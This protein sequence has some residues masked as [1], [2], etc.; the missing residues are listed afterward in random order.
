MTGVLEQGPCGSREERRHSQAPPETRKNVKIPANM[1]RSPKVSI[2]R[3][4]MVT[5]TL[6]QSQT[7][8]V[9]PWTLGL[10]PSRETLPPSEALP[11]SGVPSRCHQPMSGTAS[12]NLFPSVAAAQG[13]GGVTR[14]GGC[15]LQERPAAQFQ[16]PEPVPARQR[17]LFGIPTPH[18][19]LPR[20]QANLFLGSRGGWPLSSGTLLPQGFSSAPALPTWHLQCT[21]QAQLR[22]RETSAQEEAGCG[23]GP[24]GI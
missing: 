10:E 22:G 18:H 2:A 9:H 14:C 6:P 8:S 1:G 23:K 15:D 24:V 16:G 17:E 3:A 5:E 20:G 4:G 11:P 21:H 19:M 12:P 7:L 13:C